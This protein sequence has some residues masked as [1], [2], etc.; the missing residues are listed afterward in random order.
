MGT[1]RHFL[2]PA[3]VALLSAT[4]SAANVDLADKPLAN[5]ISNSVKPNIMFVLDDSGSMSNT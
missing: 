1:L 4:V 3:I 2:M 5:G